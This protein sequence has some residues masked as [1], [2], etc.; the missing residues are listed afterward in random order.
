MDRPIKEV[1][2]LEMRPHI[3]NR[4]EG[5]ILSKFWKPLLLWLK[6][7]RQSSHTQLLDDYHPMAPVPRSDVGP[8]LPYILAFLQAYTWVRCHPQ[9]VPLF[10]RATSASFLSRLAENSFEPKLYL[11]IPS[12]LFFLFTRPLRKQQIV[13]KRRYIKIKTPGNHP[14]E[15]TV[16]IYLF[17]NV[18]M[19][20][21]L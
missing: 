2:E 19:Y 14:K 11:A 12:Q 1:I 10:R 4:E 9:P 21:I 5:L 17:C 6:E 3:M 13:P 20:V 15:R 16:I 18:Y 8:F 7:R